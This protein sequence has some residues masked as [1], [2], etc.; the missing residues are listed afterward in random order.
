MTA[1][2]RSPTDVA[3][4]ANGAALEGARWRAVA[5]GRIGS[6][7]FTSMRNRHL[8]RSPHHRLPDEAIHEF[9][10][11]RDGER[12]R[13]QGRVQRRHRLS[14]QTGP[15]GSR[16]EANAFTAAVQTYRGEKGDARG[17]AARRAVAEIICR[18]P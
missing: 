14:H 3:N 13:G 1:G 12:C 17:E 2:G 4:P 7:F 11:E 6:E 18:K 5:V 16:N 8:A 15:P 9:P 10:P